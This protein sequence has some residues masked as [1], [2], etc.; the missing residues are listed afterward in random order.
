VKQIVVKHRYTLYRGF[1]YSFDGSKWR[2][3]GAAYRVLDVNSGETIP[4]SDDQYDP[5]GLFSEKEKA[6]H[7][8]TEAEIHHVADF[9]VLYGEA[10]E[11]AKAQGYQ[12]PQSSDTDKTELRVL[13]LADEAVKQKKQAKGDSVKVGK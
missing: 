10:W 7:T 4:S 2:K 9:N 1:T 8:L 13:Q 6:K 5:L 11:E 12:V 3:E